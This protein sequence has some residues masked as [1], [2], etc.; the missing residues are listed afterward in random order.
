MIGTGLITCS[1]SCASDSKV[2]VISHQSKQS[3]LTFL[4]FDSL[5]FMLHVCLMKEDMKHVFMPPAVSVFDLLSVS[6]VKIE[7]SG[8]HRSPLIRA[9]LIL[10]H[11]QDSATLSWLC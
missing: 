5:S 1:H 10:D 2:C 11:C 7:Q 6:A 4:L 8:T 9:S 3:F